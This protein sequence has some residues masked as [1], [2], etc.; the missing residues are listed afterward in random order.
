[1]KVFLHNRFNI[2]YVQLI[3]YNNLHKYKGK[4]Y[5]FKNNKIVLIYL[6]NLNLL[7]IGKHPYFNI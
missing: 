1:M 4:I 6:E 7:K 3:K 5:I 2:N